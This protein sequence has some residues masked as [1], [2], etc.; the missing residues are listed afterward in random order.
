MSIDPRR[1]HSVCLLFLLAVLPA[2]ADVFTVNGPGGA[3]SSPATW[4]GGVPPGP[5]DTVSLDING[6]AELVV[7]QNATVARVEVKGG[8]ASRWNTLKVAPGVALTITGDL[9]WNNFARVEQEAGS[10]LSAARYL[11]GSNG[12]G[13]VAWVIRGAPGQRVRVTGAGGIGV[14]TDP[15]NG[16]NALA[17]KVDQ[18]IDWAY[19]DFEIDGAIYLPLFRQHGADSTGLLIDHCLFDDTG[20]LDIGQYTPANAPMQ[21][22]D[23]DFRFSGSNPASRKSAQPFA[24]ASLIFKRASAT[25]PGTADD[26][27][28]NV[29]TFD[30]PDGETTYAYFSSGGPTTR[31]LGNLFKDFTIELT[32]SSDNFIEADTFEFR[33]NLVVATDALVNGANVLI[34]RK[35]GARIS[36][37]LFLSEHPNAH[38]LKTA[39]LQAHPMDLIE[40]NVFE[41]R[42][43]DAD[44]IMLGGND[45]E[46]RRNIFVGNGT[47]LNIGITGRDAFRDAIDPEA[48]NL[49]VA[50]N[51]VYT[52]TASS[53]SGLF[54]WN[55]E[56]TY[57]GG[58]VT[59]Q[60]NIVGE[61][62]DG[63]VSVYRTEDDPEPFADGIDWVDYTWLFNDNG[64]TLIPYQDILITGKTEGVDEGFGLHDQTGDPAFKNAS[65]TMAGLDGYLQGDGAGTTARL[66]REMAKRNQ[67]IAGEVHAPQYTVA[68]ALAYFR[69]AFTPQNLAL[70]DAG[71]GGEDLGAIDMDGPP[72]APTDLEP[73]RVRDGEV[74][75]RWREPTGA[76]SAYDL[77]YRAIGD[78]NWTTLAG[79]P[80][81]DVLVEGERHVTATVTALANGV[82]YEFRVSAHN[83]L[84]S[85]AFSEPS[86]P[87][88]PLPID[89]PG[90][91]TGLVVAPGSGSLAVSWGPPDDDGGAPIT[92]YVLQHKP[93]SEPSQWAV[94]MLAADVTT[95][96]L[97]GLLPGTGYDLRVHASNAA[98]EGASASLLGTTP[99]APAAPANLWA[100]AGSG[101]VQL[102]WEVPADGGLA[103]TGYVIE[104]K[105]TRESAGWTPYPADPGAAAGIAIPGLVNGEPYD[106][107]VSALNPVGSGPA[108]A[109]VSAMPGAES[110]GAMP[111]GWLTFVLPQPSALRI[112]LGFG[113]V[114][115][116]VALLG[117]QGDVIVAVG[118]SEAQDGVQRAEILRNC[119]D[120]GL[121]AGRYA[122]GADQA[123][124]SFVSGI[125]V[126]PCAWLVDDDS[127]GTPNVADNCPLLANAEQL[128]SDGDGVGDACDNCP[129]QA[130]ADQADHE[131]DGLGDVCDPDDDNDGLSDLYEQERGLDP[132][133]SA[134]AGLDPDADG[135]TTRDEHDLGTDPLKADTDGD[136]LLDGEDPEP[137]VDPASL[138]LEA[139]PSRGGWRAI[140]PLY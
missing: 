55:G 139:L 10:R 40:G 3:W 30:S 108:S 106:F 80:Y 132:R 60:S 113:A 131:P 85:S 23:S 19:A 117:P 12:Y 21:V 128:D 104:Y 103:I 42:D 53:L 33:D 61:S 58:M 93:V 22:T 84:G 25:A 127:D 17:Y 82:A 52:N 15:A 65:A 87:A 111:G 31:I 9:V 36:D 99:S 105:P 74:G 43:G 18:W 11:F 123:P 38:V 112:A 114:P 126:T 79:I 75:L 41:A 66:V 14:N 97:T 136:G 124:E 16:G 94:V 110:G 6:T 29:L 51:T 62:N 135:L 54:I 120:G 37:N 122:L 109:V 77:Q 20:Y 27:E 121:P 73:V 70:N 48:G 28:G 119:D 129:G 78:T 1:L 137:L 95:M 101:Q 118:T 4:V 35:G 130:N 56:T 72:G 134:D 47:P 115:L 125:T 59:V 26:F 76:P 100:S 8:S 90:P 71:R 91:P 13:R 34:S 102:G 92:A 49:L 44:T 81:V 57:H 69:D 116:E 46:V 39:G 32:Y 83:G 107:R 50:R 7:D 2:R 63:T 64:G 86:L 138:S 45:V 88:T 133:N 5:G 140:L 24:G 68:A 98:G 96:L 67:N 89:P